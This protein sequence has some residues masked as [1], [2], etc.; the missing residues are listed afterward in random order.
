MFPAGAAGVN[1]TLHDADNPG[2]AST[3]VQELPGENDPP[4]EYPH[5]AEPVGVDVGPN[6]K[7][8]VTV[9]VHVVGDPTS[10][11]T[12]VHDADTDVV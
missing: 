2:V 10:T 9:T 1:V 4:P 6:A 3:S 12:G 8:S 5:V 7:V 11:G